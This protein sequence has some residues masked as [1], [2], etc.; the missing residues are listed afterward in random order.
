MAYVPKICLP[1]ESI[2]KS[3]TTLC[4]EFW[5]KN[6]FCVL[7]LADASLFS[8]SLSIPSAFHNIELEIENFEQAFPTIS[9]KLISYKVALEINCNSS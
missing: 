9:H 7:K 1:S 4:P 2:E 5:S 3:F 6:A 8:F